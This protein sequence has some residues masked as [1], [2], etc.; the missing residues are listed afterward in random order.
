M[1]DEDENSYNNDNLNNNFINNNK[2][3]DKLNKTLII[4]MV[5]VIINSILIGLVTYVIIKIFEKDDK[6]KETLLLTTL[7][8]DKE[9]IKPNIK[10]NLEFELVKI[11]NNM[12]GLIINDP[13]S[14]SM[15]VQFEVQNGKLTDTIGG[16]SH[17][18][19]HMLFGGSEK[20][21]YYSFERI[22]E[23]IKDF[24]S[25]SHTGYLNQAYYISIFNN[26]KYQ[27]AIDI[28][29]DALRHPLYDKDIIEKEIQAINS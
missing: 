14:S 12:T 21:K 1:T 28:L 18:A 3:Y 11:K 4:F 20:Y 23:G 13:Y 24:Y 17:L 10:M 9:F 25:N 16:I 7:K 29:L 22:M 8:Y 27:K 19:E 5:I 15:L 2:K 26:Y 6:E